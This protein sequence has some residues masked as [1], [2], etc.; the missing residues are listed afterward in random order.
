[1]GRK[2][3]FGLLLL[4]LRLGRS[5]LGVQF[6]RCW[7]KLIMLHRCRCRHRRRRVAPGNG[8]HAIQRMCWHVG[9]TGIKRIDMM[10][11][12][13]LRV[14]HIGR[15]HVLLSATFP[16]GRKVWNRRLGLRGPGRNHILILRASSIGRSIMC[17]LWVVRSVRIVLILVAVIVVASP[18]TSSSTTS[19]L[20]IRRVRRLERHGLLLVGIVVPRIRMRGVIHGMLW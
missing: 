14:L 2:D 8:H 7:N 15:R 6:R 3:L 12:W 16:G 11:I 9:L 5:R 19:P 1:M 17:L 18:A 20:G 4:L 10:T 13:Q